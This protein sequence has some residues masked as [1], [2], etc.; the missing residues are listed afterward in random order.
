[1]GRPLTSEKGKV[2]F[3]T[4]TRICG[5]NSP[6]LES[7]MERMDENLLQATLVNSAEELT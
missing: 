5:L 2:Q 6:P 4:G 3:A 7:H 1:M